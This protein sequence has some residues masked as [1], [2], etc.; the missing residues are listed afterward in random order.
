MQLLIA[1]SG[2]L[3]R[4]MA[5]AARPLGVD[6]SFVAEPDE[7]TSAV[8]GLGTLVQWS[9]GASMDDLLAVAPT[10]ITTEKEKVAPE[11]IAA[12]SRLA[13]FRP[14]PG[15]LLTCQDRALE[16]RFLVDH[17]IGT[18]AFADVPDAAALESALTGLRFPLVLK[19]CRSGYDGKHQWRAANRD[20][21]EC[22]LPSLVFPLIAEEFI[23]FTRELS[24]NVVRDIHGATQVYP[25]M[26]NQHRN[27]ILVT[28][29]APAPAMDD[30]E[31]AAAVAI[32]RT[33]AEALDYVG[34]MTVEL[35][36]CPDG[37]L[38]VN[39]LAP[40]PHNSGHWTMRGTPVCQF[41]NHVRAVL[42][43]PI[44][45][46]RV[47]EPVAMV[48][49][50]GRLPALGPLLQ[51]DI[52]VHLYQKAERPGRKLGHLLIAGEESTLRA[53]ADALLRRIE[54]P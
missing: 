43:L 53:R 44:A 28:T 14:A 16:K 5:L 50:L 19:A 13:P 22:L 12:L 26:E 17:G 40:R 18:A 6:C 30:R 15:A 41:A 24:V 37:R 2:Q 47:I 38:L 1:G 31:I 42:G 51:E 7:D 48:N 25:V 35:F 10:A 52:E 36:E 9:P 32:G 4:M 33:I 34:S 46:P 54:S 20:E 23:A 45:S 8:A 49:V 29:I 3:A 27:G 11:L 21:L 39:E